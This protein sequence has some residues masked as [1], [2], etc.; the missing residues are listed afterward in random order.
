MSKLESYLLYVGPLGLIGFCMAA[1]LVYFL[2]PRHFFLEASFAFYAFWISMSKMTGFTGL[3]T[4]MKLTPFVPGVIL[5]L[6][7]CKYRKHRQWDVPSYYWLTPIVFVLSA[8]FLMRT[9]DATSA[10]PLRLTYGFYVFLSLLVVQRFSVEDFRKAFVGLAMG[11]AAY[12]VIVISGLLF[13]AN[14]G[15]IV[16][17]GRFASYGS[18]PNQVAFELIPAVACMVFA[19]LHASQGKLVFKS[20][21]LAAL[22]CALMSALLSGSRQAIFICSALTLAPFLT[23]R[24]VKYV[25]L[26]LPLV[27]VAGLFALRNEEFHAAGRIFTFDTTRFE[28]FMMYYSYGDLF[29]PFG[30]LLEAG[31]F[32]TLDEAV[33]QHAHN[34]FI[35]S[36]HAFGFIVSGFHF[37]MMARFLMAGLLQ[38]KPLVPWVQAMQRIVLAFIFASFALCFFGY[39][40]IYPTF[41]LSFLFCLFGFMA[42]RFRQLQRI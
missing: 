16:G 26:A 32:S 33:G 18:N 10:V 17:L 25:F 27:V 35:Y 9:Y 40:P 42:I 8:F 41:T 37:M 21:L 2:L 4:L 19:F 5:L 36:L 24:S 1:A 30:M 13:A 3:A 12:S 28:I 29:K 39:S 34:A 31:G 6:F 14:S 22:V 23:L 20:F 7:I 11:Y 15:F 38:R